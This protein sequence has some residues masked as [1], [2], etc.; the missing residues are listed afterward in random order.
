MQQSKIIFLLFSLSITACI[1]AVFGDLITNA[2]VTHTSATLNS[3]VETDS[4][5]NININDICTSCSQLTTSTTHTFA[6]ESSNTYAT[7]NPHLPVA[8]KTEPHET[9]PESIDDD[10]NKAKTPYLEAGQSRTFIYA[11]TGFNYTNPEENKDIN[12]DNNNRYFLQPGQSRTFLANP[13]QND[14]ISEGE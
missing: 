4:L 7:D 1:Y 13:Q 6:D 8:Y 11:S 14:Y 9:D 5:K 2:Q 3:Y 10:T 12:E